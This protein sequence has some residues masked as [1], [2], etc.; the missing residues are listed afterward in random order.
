M[1][2]SN[3]SFLAFAIGFIL[4]ALFITRMFFTPAEAEAAESDAKSFQSVREMPPLTPE[5][6]RV[7]IDKGTE[8]PYSGVYESNKEAGFYICRQCGAFLYRSEAKFDSGCG[9]PSFD[10]EVSGAVKHS[11]DP[12]GTRTEITCANCDAHLGHV[13]KGEGFTAK[14][15]RHCVNSISMK[16]IPASSSET[17][18]F[19]GGCF[20][21][22]EHAF[23][24]LPGI[25]DV[26]SGY[27]GGATVNPG[28]E[29]VSSGKT[30][31]AETV[32][33]IFEPAKVSYETLARLF[34]E[35]HDPT[36]LNRQGPDA[37]TQYRSAVFPVTAEQK[38]TVEKLIRLLNEK[39]WHTVTSIEPD[40]VFYPAE[41]YHQRYIEKHPN[42]SCHAPYPR[43]DKGPAG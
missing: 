31:H 15:T 42:Y 7:I 5:E 40:K 11:P 30:G 8:S 29:D 19:A 25:I 26:T 1:S 4:F 41:A 13:F 2:A 22:V 27:M 32:R 28:Y 24:Q 37:G 14:N 36:Q 10:E 35:I 39:G 38:N 12:D 33:V 9:W 34:F 23:R 18:Y 20:W 6:K 3:I 17:A 16:F 21:G 43:F